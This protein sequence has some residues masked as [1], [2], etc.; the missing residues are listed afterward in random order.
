MMQSQLLGHVP[1]CARKQQTLPTL[2]RV[3]WDDRQFTGGQGVLWGYMQDCECIVGRRAAIMYVS[4]SA[5]VESPQ[6]A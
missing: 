2:M 3:Q 4:R 1:A 5:C 6:A